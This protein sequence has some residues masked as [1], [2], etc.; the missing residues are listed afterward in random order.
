MKNPR[1]LLFVLLLAVLHSSVAHNWLH[2][3]SRVP[4]LSTTLPIPNAPTAWTPHLQVGANQ[5][6]G[7]S[8]V[9]GHPGSYYYFV[10]LNHKAALPSPPFCTDQPRCVQDYDRIAD[11]TE[12]DLNQ[13]LNAAPAANGLT[14]QRYE[15]DRYQVMHISC[16]HNGLPNSGCPQTTRNSGAQ[17]ERVPMMSTK[18]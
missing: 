11:Y 6:F 1:T 10:I 7:V 17:Y 8:W 9:C 15:E 5:D 13:Y 12:A 4:K 14:V 18:Q 3:R 16:S 2:M